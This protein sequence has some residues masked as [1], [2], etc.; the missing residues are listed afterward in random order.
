MSGSESKRRVA[1]DKV[2]RYLLAQRSNRK[3]LKLSEQECHE[4]LRFICNEAAIIAQAKDE[5]VYE[6]H[7]FKKY[8]KEKLKSAGIDALVSLQD[9]LIFLDTKKVPE[10]QPY[11]D[12]F[13]NILIYL[14]YVKLVGTE[15][16]YKAAVSELKPVVAQLVLETTQ[17]RMSNETEEEKQQAIDFY[18]RH[19]SISIPQDLSVN[20][21]GY[22]YQE[23][24]RIKDLEREEVI[25]ALIEKLENYIKN[26]EKEVV[27]LAPESQDIYR[28]RNISGSEE[29]LS[30]A[31]K[32]KKDL[33]NE[34]ISIED[35]I[36]FVKNAIASDDFCLSEE[37][38]SKEIKELLSDLNKKLSGEGMARKEMP[39]DK[40][41]LAD[42]DRDLYVTYHPHVIP[43]SPGPET[44]KL[45]SE[46]AERLRNE[47]RK[48]TITSL[49]IEVNAY[50][51]KNK[52]NPYEDVK[53]SNLKKYKLHIANE[54]KRTL[55]NRL[56]LPKEKI[57]IVES[58]LKSEDAKAISEHRNSFKR[59]TE[60]LLDGAAKLLDSFAKNLSGK[61][62]AEPKEEKKGS[63]AQCP[64]RFF[65]PP[66][67]AILQKDFHTKINELGLR[68]QA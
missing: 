43:Q 30:L 62:S 34:T 6:S 2:E 38:I 8:P 13:K 58:I 65:A 56:I 28:P 67:G 23:N 9:N 36:L 11:K 64:A 12:I 54:M 4:A 26:K 37:D 53:V 19:H 63:N 33:E 60:N 5:I 24:K 39:G 59:N 3:V 15:E 50:I 61:K 16:E 10:C 29:Q 46:E 51:E 49:L 35:K 1:I 48:E 32:I 22:I 41:K 25:A 57:L 55:S 47:E 20:E 68:L 66:R 14:A 17:L 7:N 42:N 27:F 40:S 44:I 21:M 31:V 52:V 45:I 18:K